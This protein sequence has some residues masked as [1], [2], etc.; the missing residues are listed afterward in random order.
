MLCYAI[1][2]YTPGAASVSGGI[3][4][5]NEVI[6]TEYKNCV[7]FIGIQEGPGACAPHCL[8]QRRSDLMQ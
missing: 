3:S 7:V 4:S 6:R 5:S 8:G 2:E 1:L